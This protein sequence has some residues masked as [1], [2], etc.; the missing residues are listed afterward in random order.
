VSEGLRPVDRKIEEATSGSPGRR[1]SKLSLQELSKLARV[2]SEEL[3]AHPTLKDR[4]VARIELIEA[5]V[6]ARIVDPE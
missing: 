2:I 6:H 4:V 1:E 3:F 5:E